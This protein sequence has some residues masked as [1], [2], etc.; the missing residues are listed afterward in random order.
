MI[1]LC[2]VAIAFLYKAIDSQNLAMG[3]IVF[4]LILLILSRWYIIKTLEKDDGKPV[5]TKSDFIYRYFED[6]L[7]LFAEMK[8][9]YRLG[10]CDV[11]YEEN[12][13]ILLYDHTS[14]NYYSSAKTLAGAKDIAHKLPQDYGMLIAHDEF[15]LQLDKNEFSYQ[16]LLKFYNHVYDKRTKYIIPENDFTFKMLDEQY[17][18]II[19]KHYSIEELCDDEYLLGRIKD[20]MMGAFIDEK[21]VGFIGIH[22]NGAVG[23]LEVFPEYQGKHI[24][25]Y[26][27]CNYVNYLI[28]K[29]YEGTI[30]TQTKENNEISIRIQKKL[31]FRKAEKL[32]LWFFEK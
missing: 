3:M 6:D 32:A 24:A 19:K 7:F 27:Q 10:N 25:T 17:L 26:L 28:D 15:L 5:S 12:D 14:K 9:V 22:D 2:L 16:G 1:I 31:N 30:Y 18:E 23:L 20:G 4:L 29:K 8:E 21:I 13:G 11:L